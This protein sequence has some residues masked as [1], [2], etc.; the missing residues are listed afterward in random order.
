M[1]IIMATTPAPGHVNPMLGIVRILVAEG[2]A[3]VAF[4]GS[5]FQERVTSLGAVFRAIPVSADQDLVDPFSK[6]PELKNTPP[7]LELLRLTIE[8]LF[9]DH[10]P[11]QYQGLQRVL[12]EVPSD[13]VIGDDFLLGLLP[14]LLGPRSKRPP[15][16]LFGTSILHSHRDDRAPNFLGLPPAATRAQRDQYV[17]VAQEYDSIV[18]QPVAHRVNRCLESLGIGPLSTPVLETFVEL[19]DVYM[20]LTV[21]GFEF[22]WPV[23]PTVRFVGTLPII[24]NQAPLPSWADDLDG[25]HK[26][27]LVTQGTVANHDFG[28]LVAPTLAALANEPD[29]LVVVTAG[30]RPVEAIPGPLPANARLASYLPFEWILPK[31]DVLVTNGGYGSVNQA[32][33]FGVPLVTAGLTEDK[34]DVNV[35]VAWSGVGIDLATNNPTPEA[36]RKAIRSVLDTQDYRQ[37]VALMAR[38]FQMIDTRAEILRIVSEVSQEGSS[39]NPEQARAVD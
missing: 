11:A 38:E 31:V 13:I 17:A 25:R 23:P 33:S 36:L 7:G 19:A 2:H 39:A 34:A 10:I 28:I 30:G 8:R 14:M 37:R 21:P 22:P 6:Y 12:R 3:V 26:V 15:I 5:A 29:V 16:A 4:T 24:P 20:Q 27:V 1:N 32:M 18:N 35:R 9:V